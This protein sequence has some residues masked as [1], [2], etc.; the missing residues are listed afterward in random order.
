MS[1][2][3]NA[4]GREFQRDG[5]ATEKLLSPRRVRVLFVEDISGLHDWQP[6]SVKSWQSSARNSGSWPC[7]ALYTRT[8]ILKSI[9]CQT[10]NQCSSR[11]TGVICCRLP[12]CI[13]IQAAAFCTDWSFCSRLPAIPHS[14]HLVVNTLVTWPGIRRASADWLWSVTVAPG[15]INCSIQGK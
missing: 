11:R 2:S 15:H 14:R 6:M 10:G 4:T 12:V 7:N 1:L 3:H 9:H 5:P 8:A 13:I